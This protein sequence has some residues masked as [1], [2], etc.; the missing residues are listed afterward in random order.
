MNLCS[1]V[2]GCWI[3]PVSGYSVRSVALAGFGINSIIE[4][5]TFVVILWLRDESLEDAENLP[6]PHIIAAEIVEDLEAALAQF[7]EIVE[8]LAPGL[9]HGTAVGGD[10][11]SMTAAADPAARGAL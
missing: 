2:A 8:T 10:G 5:F 3:V 11:T 6:A 9:D 7:A 1:N 4:I